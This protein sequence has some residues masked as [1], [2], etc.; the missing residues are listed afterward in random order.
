MHNRL[1]PDHGGKVFG[2]LLSALVRL[3]VWLPLIGLR[4]ARRRQ[5]GRR[6]VVEISVGGHEGS[7]ELSRAVEVF[8]AMA[9]DPLVRAALVR[10]WLPGA[11]VASAA[12]LRAAIVQV[13]AAGVEVDVHLETAG[14]AALLASS[15]ANR[16]WLVPSTDLNLL[17]LGGETL[18]FG[19]A[20]ARFGVTAEVESAGR[21]KSFGE[22]WARGFA[23][24]ASRVSMGGLLEDL[25]E[26]VLAAIA[27]SRGLPVEAVRAAMEEAPLSAVAARERGLVDRVGFVDQ[28]RAEL[29]GRLGE[30]MRPVKLR[31]YLR[32]RRWERRLERV[33]RRA[34][35]IAVVHLHG[36][37][38]HG[39]EASGGGG[40]R[41][42]A[43]RIVPALDELRE[44]AGVVGVV[45]HIDSPGGSAL[46]SDLIARAVAR[47]VASK[48]TIAVLGDVAASGGY[49]VAAPCTR[50]FAS[51]A[52]VTGSIG[53]V[54]GKLALGPALARLGVH[55]ERFEAGPGGG[56][57][58][59][60]QPFTD[61][62]RT[63]FRASLSRAYERFIGV[64][65]A[66]RRLPERAVIA[67]AEGRVWTGRQAVGLGLVDELGGV[68]DAL[69]AV[70]L[71][72][73]APDARELRLTFPPPR[74]ALLQALMHR[75]DAP[76]LSERLLRALGP[77]A[78]SLAVLHA[79]PG[80]P[81]ALHPWVVRSR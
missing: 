35:T 48:P 11:S 51:S 13:R 63:R 12:A 60:W 3:L 43:E 39:L 26:Q 1:L 2:T 7:V 37:V 49:Y 54:G 10:L 70:R 31:R 36:P 25:L 34:S 52:T 4:L 71:L 18:F 42:D 55:A 46:A 23:S 29:E 47:L 79:H 24:A 74:L 30:E 22:T 73:G 78:A 16:V 68:R 62:Q 59:P 67:A 77:E 14:T 72:A 32:L 19:D 58:S 38:V 65:S 53:V 66:G 80:E 5:L 17:G 20:L 40:Q 41:I 33:G 81:L 75:A 9:E 27:A 64:V 15:A 50:I 28:A 56:Q 44:H 8:E 21:Y 57:F 69:R 61:E 45:L 6:G 76:D